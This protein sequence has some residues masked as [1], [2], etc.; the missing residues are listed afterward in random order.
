M[1]IQVA[2]LLAD[3]T[4]I[5]RDFSVLESVRDNYPK[6]VLSLDKHFNG[7]RKGIKW[8]NLVDYLVTPE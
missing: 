2:Y 6:I 4:V 5:E 7:E 1:Y 8:F 3:E